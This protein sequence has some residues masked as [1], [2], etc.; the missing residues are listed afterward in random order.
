MRISDVAK[1]EGAGGS[2]TTYSFTITLSMAAASPMGV[3]ATTSNGTAVASGDYTAESQTLSFAAGQQTKTFT[4]TVK[5]DG[6][7]EANETFFVDLSNPTGAGGGR[8]RRPGP[9]NDP[10]RRPTVCLGWCGPQARSA[11]SVASRWSVIAPPALSGSPLRM[12]S[13]SFRCC[14]TV[15]PP[16]VSPSRRAGWASWRA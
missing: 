11:V 9:G 16:S 13:R 1:S 10:Q 6:T 8:D 5:G 2:H 7:R 14:A 12:A 4:V 15:S 3:T